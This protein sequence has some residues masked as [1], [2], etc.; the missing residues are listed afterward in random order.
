ML[1]VIVDADTRDVADRKR[2]FMR[3]CEES[4]VPWIADDDRVVMIVPKRNIESW[5]VYLTGDEWNEESSE[6]RRKNDAL[7]KPAGKALNH[8]C[9]VDQRLRQPAPP[10]L[11]EA[12]AEWRRKFK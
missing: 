1:V 3:E 10:S 6:W 2:Q 11:E 9:Y 12:C 5:F 4:N 8:M 7:A